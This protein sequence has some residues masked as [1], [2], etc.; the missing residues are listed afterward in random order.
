MKNEIV[1]TDIFAKLKEEIN[2]LKA[3]IARLMQEKHE[4]E[5]VICPELN[6]LFMDK[7][8]G[9][10]NRIRAQQ[11]MVEELK[12]R[13]QLVQAALNREE[14][15]K[16]SEVDKKVSEEYEEYHKKIDEQFKKAEEDKKQEE[17]RK[18]K[19]AEQEAQFNRKQEEREKEKSN[20]KSADDAEGSNEDNQRDGDSK[21]A[22][23]E[24]QKDE[25]EGMNYKQKLK[26]LYRRLVKKL[27]PDM[28]EN[29]TEREKELWNKVQEA[30][31]EGDIDTLEEIYNE[32]NENPVDEVE[33]NE[34]GRE[35]L[36]KLIELLR[37]QRARL[38]TEIEII[39]NDFPYCEKEFLEDEDAV[40]RKQ[41]ELTEMIEEYE[42]LI[43]K[44]TKRLEELTEGM[45]V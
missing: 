40:A 25:F 3:D 8:G 30:Y 20:R 29:I 18:K 14:K 15:V 32:I 11:L 36:E 41:Q 42:E 17:R 23:N 12:F 28:N 7:I 38:L 22:G 35:K 2:M 31:R 19:E 6:V 33:E 16:Q 21:N 39:K 10:L 27:H 5:G 44:L 34:D 13:I 26:E 9:L 4:L 45:P 1:L 43:G 37:K 24:G